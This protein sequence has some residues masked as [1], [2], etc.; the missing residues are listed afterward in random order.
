MNKDKAE[1]VE[2]AENPKKSSII[3]RNFGEERQSISVLVEFGSRTAA[4][5]SFYPAIAADDAQLKKLQEL[6]G[7][8]PKPTFSVK[9]SGAPGFQPAS[10]MGFESDPYLA[11]FYE[12]AAES[13]NHAID[14]AKEIVK[15]MSDSVLEVIPVPPAIPAIG[16]ASAEPASVEA[17]TPDFRSLQTYLGPGPDGINAYL[18]WQ[19]PGGDGAGVTVA[20]I[21]G[22]WRLMHENLA[23]VRYNHWGGTLVEGSGWLEH[24]TAVVGMLGGPR[25]ANGVTGICPGARVGMISAFEG[26]EGRTQRV[27]NQI[28]KALEFLSPGDVMLLELQRPGPT[29]S[30]KPNADQNGY[31][32]VSYWP[33]VRAAISRVVARGVC[34]VEVGGNGGVSLDDPAYEGRFDRS[35]YDTGSI[36]VGAGAPPGGAFGQPRSRLSFSNYGQRLDCQGWGQMVTTS[37]YGDLWNGNN[38]VNQ[39]YTS[40]FMGTSSA[41]PIVAGVIACMQG[42]HKLVYGRPIAPAMVRSALHYSGWQQS[43]VQTANYQRIG[44]Q[45]DLSM[46]FQIFR[47]IGY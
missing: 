23:N 39:T 22:G 46:L 16:P 6:T 20:D 35:R 21:E 10:M 38:S 36:M 8:T 5:A 26:S 17:V 28:L 15:G 45:P 31:L 14:M 24:G 42:R 29:T 13:G 43:N 34:V 25:D 4:P 47:L 1:K 37:G 12:V 27:A 3:V 19:F 30:F 32:P 11:N 41:A 2:K 7:V 33:D 44:N 18:A 40:R 9:P